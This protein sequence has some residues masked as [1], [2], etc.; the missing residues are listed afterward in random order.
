MTIDD[1]KTILINNLSVKGKN[2][3]HANREIVNQMITENPK[4]EVDIAEAQVFQMGDTVVF[5][6]DSGISI[7]K[8]VVF[9]DLKSREAFLHEPDKD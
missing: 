7:P 9:V 6:S 2:S 4:Q 3:I 5:L 1:V 8:R